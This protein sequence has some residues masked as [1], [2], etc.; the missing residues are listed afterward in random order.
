MQDSAGWACEV[1]KGGSQPPAAWVSLSWEPQ[2]AGSS[3]PEA[4]QLPPLSHRQV[5]EVLLGQTLFSS[6]PSAFVV[7]GPTGT[8]KVAAG[9][10]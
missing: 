10:L 4:G 3:R 8:Q 2:A 1:G 9:L 6:Q 5:Q 7:G